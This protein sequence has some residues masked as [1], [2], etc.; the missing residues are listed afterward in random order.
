MAALVV[1]GKALAVAGTAHAALAL[2]MSMIHAFSVRI[3]IYLIKR[4]IETASRQEAPCK[5]GLGLTQAAGRRQV[6]A[7]EFR[8]AD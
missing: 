8:S 1:M 7:I 2:E 5:T 6:R 4:Y 3:S